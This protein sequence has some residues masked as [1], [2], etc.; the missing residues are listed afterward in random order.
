MIH[1]NRIRK[2][3]KKLQYG[4]QLYDILPEYKD[5]FVEY[6]GPDTGIILNTAIQLQQQYDNIL[7]EKKEALKSIRDAKVHTIYNGLKTQLSD[8]ILNANKNLLERSNN[9]ILSPIYSQGILNVVDEKMNGKEWTAAL[10]NSPQ[11]EEY[12]TNK[13]RML[14]KGNVQNY[15]DP[16]LPVYN[17]MLKGNNI[18]NPFV[19]R[20]IYET[21]N[22]DAAFDAM[23]KNFPEEEL[24]SFLPVKITDDKGNV[25]YAPFD[26]IKMEAKIKSTPGLNER[27]KTLV[28]NFYT[29]AEG[30][31]FARKVAQDI[32][33]PPNPDGSVDMNNPILKDAYNKQVLAMMNR[34]AIRNQSYKEESTIT[35][36]AG[37]ERMA[38]FNQQMDYNAAVKQADIDIK[39]NEWE[40]E[41]ELERYKAETA[42]INATNGNSGSNDTSGASG[43]TT[44]KGK[45]QETNYGL[46]SGAETAYSTKVDLSFEEDNKVNYNT[47]KVG[48][49]RAEEK[50]KQSMN[51]A[52]KAISSN[53]ILITNKDGAAF[54]NYDNTNKNIMYED[55]VNYYD[56]HNSLEGLNINFEGGNNSS[57]QYELETNVKNLLVEKKLKASSI[58]TLNSIHKNA[59]EKLKQVTKSDGTKLYMQVNNNPNALYDKLN[60]TIVTLSSSGELIVVD[61]NKSAFKGSSIEDIAK[62][63]TFTPIKKDDNGVTIAGEDIKDD[64][65]ASGKINFLVSNG[66]YKRASYSTSY[67]NVQ[68]D[69]TAKYKSLTPTQI[70]EVDRA[71]LLSEEYKKANEASTK[72][73][74]AQIAN[75]P[76][77]AG[78]VI[79]KLNDVAK[80]SA[81]YKIT[82]QEI[83]SI[84]NQLTT[85]QTDKNGDYFDRMRGVVQ[86][87]INAPDNINLSVY[88]LNSED[89]EKGISPTYYEALKEK[90]KKFIDD[91][92]FTASPTVILYGVA[93]NDKIGGCF[94][95][96]IAYDITSVMKNQGEKNQEKIDDITSLVEGSG[97]KL[98]IQEGIDGNTYLIDNNSFLV[99][100]E[101]A[102]KAIFDRELGVG[103]ESTGVNNQYNLL[104]KGFNDTELTILKIDTY[105]S[106]NDIHVEKHVDDNYNI[107]YRI[108][109]KDINGTNEYTKCTTLSEVAKL[110]YEYN[111]NLQKLNTTVEQNP[112]LSSINPNNSTNA[113]QNQ[114]LLTAYSNLVQPLQYQTIKNKSDRTTYMSS[115]SA[116][117]Y[118]DVS[119]GNNTS[120]VSFIVAKDDKT[121]ANYLLL[122]A[123]R[124]ISNV[125]TEISGVITKVA[126]PVSIEDTTTEIDSSKFSNVQNN[127]LKRYFGNDVTV[128]YRNNKLII[129]RKTK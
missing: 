5:G 107:D 122:K 77:I 12:E 124:E 70:A 52:V 96:K 14:E 101:V 1:T 13:Q 38:E 118:Y 33:L 45:A 129:S 46:L 10:G 22:Y 84:P 8:E 20:G 54:G 92:R 7:K 100:S 51:T 111:I 53:N 86:T 9:D 98:T 28:D 48:V 47:Y 65:I 57:M 74:N 126:N 113:V 125:D 39:R 114:L 60:H 94:Y 104:L 25:T 19:P 42:R 36:L 106:T 44:P 59:F 73:I 58:E 69:F 49:V 90:S 67:G 64:N 105:S 34:A 108:Y 80:T 119:T 79:R 109:W 2:S 95:G 66:Y 117:L 15:D 128:I 18:Y 76:G 55:L 83:I 61:I 103:D 31:S 110:T 63:V 68:E 72:D 40:K 78:D 71:Y 30:A 91:S 116:K 27:Y 16:N 93:K 99:K 11:L 120:E 112:Y 121:H 23:A 115:P 50:Y 81:L 82:N 35:T 43:K 37:Q 21:P 6:K 56:L 87:M 85:K 41:Q 97:N 17:E 3:K 24:T 75:K 123:I 102:N 32:G 88:E 26:V 4:G 127:I 89:K 62:N 29:T